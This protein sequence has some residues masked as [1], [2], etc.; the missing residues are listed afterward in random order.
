MPLRPQSAKAKGRRLQQKVATSIL[1]AFPHLQSDD[2][3]STSMGAPGEDVR[4][5]PAARECVPLSLECKCQEK[6][7]IWACLEQATANTPPSADAACVVFT[8]NH[9]KTYAVVPWDFLLDL[10]KARRSQGGGSIPPQV[11]SLVKELAAL[12]SE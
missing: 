5:S 11:R 12:V 9:A 8:R 4:M 2:V 7:S 3:V 10:L 1:D 6:I